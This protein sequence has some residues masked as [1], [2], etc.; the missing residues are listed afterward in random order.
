[1]KGLHLAAVVKLTRALSA[2]VGTAQRTTPT[3]EEQPGMLARALVTSDSARRLALAQ[4]S[5]GRIDEARSCQPRV[6]G[7]RQRS[8]SITA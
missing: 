3:K 1:M 6:L 2:T 8:T 5:D 7:R 4:V